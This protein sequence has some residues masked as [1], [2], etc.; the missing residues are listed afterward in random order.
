MLNNYELYN[1]CL[2][3]FSPKKNKTWFFTLMYNAVQKEILQKRK[4]LSNSFLSEADNI[5]DN[6]I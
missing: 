3:D 2:I 1:I 5:T 6:F 4:L